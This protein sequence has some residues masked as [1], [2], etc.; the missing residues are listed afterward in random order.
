MSRDRMS[1]Q[2][3]GNR[4]LSWRIPYLTGIEAKARCLPTEAKEDE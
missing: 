1:C 3:A 2:V 4:K